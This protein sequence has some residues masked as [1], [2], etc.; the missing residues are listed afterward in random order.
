LQ[1]LQPSLE[2][3]VFPFPIRKSTSSFPPSV[4]AIRQFQTA[5]RLSRTT[6]TPPEKG[7]GG[8]RMRRHDYSF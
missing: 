4:S 1:P 6:L 5:S 7:V 8:R 2:L 3:I